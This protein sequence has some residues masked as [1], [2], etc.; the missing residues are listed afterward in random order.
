MSSEEVYICPPTSMCTGSVNLLA[1]ATTG[2]PCPAGTEDPPVP[3]SLLI[4]CTAKL[5]M[6]TNFSETELSPTCWGF[7]SSTDS[8]WGRSGPC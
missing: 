5:L 7:P 2:I 8:Y 3:A 1:V 4:E 6:V